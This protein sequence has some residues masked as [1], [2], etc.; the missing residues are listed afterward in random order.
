MILLELIETGILQGLILAVV[1]LGVMIPFRLV[2]FPDLTAEGSY[3]LGAAACASLLIFG[4]PPILATVLASIAAGLLGVGTAL[5]HLRFRINTLLAGI[6]LS[7]MVYSVNLRLMSGPNI[8]L[9]E[10]NTLFAVVNADFPKISIIILIIL[11]LVVPLFL[12]LITEKG[13]CFRAVGLNPEFC[14]RQGLSI[15]RYTLFGLFLGNSMVGLAGSLMVQL[16]NY[17]DIGMGIGIIIHAL[18]ALMIGESIIGN[19]SLKRQIIAPLLGAIIYQ[20]IQ[21]G[22]LALGLPPSDLKFLTGA[23]VLSIIAIRGRF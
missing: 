14:R 22:V 17:A 13:L 16:Q 20:Q 10:Y 19:G 2:N 23:I 12:F 1:A 5:V 4:A 6:I 8:A 9:F 7:T 11:V 15:A 18:A 21:G 3:P